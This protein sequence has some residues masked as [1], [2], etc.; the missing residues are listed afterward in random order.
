MKFK[1]FFEFFQT[2]GSGTV[3]FNPNLYK[4]VFPYLEKFYIFVTIIL[5]RCTIA[6]G[7]CFFAFSFSE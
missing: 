7:W 2:T 5:F 6:Q 4:Y 3:R 1:Y